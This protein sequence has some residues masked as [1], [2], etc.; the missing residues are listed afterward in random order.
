MKKYKNNLIANV[1]Y[2]KN[3]HHIKNNKNKNITV[4]D[5]LILKKIYQNFHNKIRNFKKLK[6]QMEIIRN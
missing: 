2:H 3:N 6:E 4:L 5:N 1:I